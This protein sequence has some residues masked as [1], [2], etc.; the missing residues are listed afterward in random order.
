[1]EMYIYDAI[2]NNNSKLQLGFVKR[3]WGKN[4][5]ESKKTR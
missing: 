1:M 5:A 3:Y 2:V 4:K